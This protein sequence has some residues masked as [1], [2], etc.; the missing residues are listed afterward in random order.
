MIFTAIRIAVE[1]AVILWGADRFTDGACAIARKWGASELLIG[2]TIVAMGTSMPEFVVSFFSALSGSADM[3][4]GN[5][6]GSNIFNTLVI[7]SATALVLP[8]VV[9]R[10]T[11]T[12]DIPLCLTATVL[13]TIFACMGHLERWEA[14]LLFGIFLLFVGYNIRTAI[15]QVKE[16]ETQREQMPAIKIIFLLVIGVLCLVLG[17]EYLVDDATTVA[18]Y[19]GVPEAVIGLTILAGGTSLPELATSIV[20]AKKGAVGLA[21]GNAIGSNIFNITFVLGICG[22]I[23]PN[24][25][26]MIQGLTWIDWVTLIGSLLLLWLF[27]GITKKFVR[28]EGI[29][30]LLIYF[31]YLTYLIM[32]VL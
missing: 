13:L 26:M 10:S 2:L 14:L 12:K 24:S 30:F 8:I 1:I 3:S 19:F 4:V 6:V 29:V 15:H 20:A 31:I 23:T 5:V 18:R 21:V 27:C 11:M 25:P 32:N 16:S 7:V 9:E 17:G 28:W 22:V